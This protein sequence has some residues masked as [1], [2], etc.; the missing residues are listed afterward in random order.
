MNYEP[1]RFSLTSRFKELNRLYGQLSTI[2]K[3]LYLKGTFPNFVD[4][5]LFG[6]TAPETIAERRR[7]I[8]SFLN[9]VLDSDVLRKARVFQA[10]IEVGVDYSEF[11]F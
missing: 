6:T 11:F 8:E 9:F 10:F 5:R 4:A 2:H 7:A 3:Q 1:R